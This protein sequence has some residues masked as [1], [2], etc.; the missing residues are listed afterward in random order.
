MSYVRTTV[1]ALMLAG[2]LAGCT[3]E[4]PSP[5]R[6]EAMAEWRGG[7]NPAVLT[8]AGF[9]PGSAS[10]ALSEAAVAEQG[11]DLATAQRRYEDAALAWPDLAE[12]WRGLAGTAAAQGRADTAAG[13]QFV[14]S[15]VEV[16]PSDEIWVQRE[17]N[18]ALRRYIDTAAVD[19]AGNPEAVRYVTRLVEYYDALYGSAGVYQGPG[20]PVFNL[21]WRDVPAAAI[22]LAASVFYISSLSQAEATE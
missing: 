6:T 20:R 7:L 12:A 10:V 1:S 2:V 19:P 11:G 5:P 17:I 21:G 15:R 3:A 18:A 13:A 14:L 9:D 22:S 8:N 16:F 4:L